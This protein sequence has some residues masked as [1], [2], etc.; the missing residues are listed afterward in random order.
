MGNKYD[1]SKHDKSLHLFYFIKRT[2][3]A[4]AAYKWLLSPHHERES[5]ETK[6]N[7]CDIRAQNESR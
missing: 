2:E 6:D 7:Q 3:G 4:D 5:N 1:A